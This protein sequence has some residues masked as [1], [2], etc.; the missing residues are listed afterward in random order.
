MLEQTAAEAD[1]SPSVKG[2]PWDVV[3]VRA[4]PDHRLHARFRDG[5]AGVV[6]MKAAVHAPD[7]GVFARLADP[8][9]FAAV[10]IEGGAVTWPGALDA[11]PWSL[12]LA[13]DAMHD[14][15]AERGEWTLV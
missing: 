13:P 8:A 12:D 5:V 9:R 6:N 7:A 4:L 15:L 14:E 11:W 10:T 3:E 2:A 1:Q